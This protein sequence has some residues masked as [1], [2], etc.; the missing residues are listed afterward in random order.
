MSNRWRIFLN[1]LILALVAGFVAYMIVSVGGA[2]SEYGEAEAEP[3]DF[4]SPCSREASFAV[5]QGIRHIKLAGDTLFLASS[6]SVFLYGTDGRPLNRFGASEGIVD[7]ALGGGLVYLLYPARIMVFEASG[8]FVREWEA[9]SDRSLYISIALTERYA[10]V[11]D[12]ENKNICQYRLEGGFV[13]FISSPRGFVVPMLSFA[14]ES[15]RDT[16]YCANPG[17][18]TVE[19]YSE[20]GTF[21]ASFGI[22]GSKPGAFSGCSNPAF[23]AFTESGQLLS[24]EKGNPRV[25]LFE[26]SGR[27]SGMML[28][29]KMLGGGHEAYEIQATTNRIYAAG[30]AEII[31]YK[32]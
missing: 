7:I 12:A 22:P 32:Y 5:P 21:L 23:I 4:V 27:F 19:S 1:L 31:A 29:A 16:V 11:T 20:D 6:D 13:R 25:C 10:F 15:F 18:H 26:R 28:N 3:D 8:N 2:E 24:S 17:R 14:I 9:C 30:R